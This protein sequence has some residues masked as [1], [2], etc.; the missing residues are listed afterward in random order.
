[1]INGFS[2]DYN[3]TSIACVGMGCLTLFGVVYLC[4]GH[5]S[6]GALALATGIGG[7]CAGALGYKVG[8]GE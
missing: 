8:R 3:K 4:M 6:I 1:M 5:N 7:V 2:G